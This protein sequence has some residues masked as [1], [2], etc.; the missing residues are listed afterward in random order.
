MMTRL[1]RGS[2]N[3]EWGE[4]TADSTEVRT[5]MSLG[6]PNFVGLRVDNVGV[7]YVAKMNGMDIIQARKSGVELDG[8]STTVRLTGEIDN[9]RIPVWWVSHVNNGEVSEVIVEPS[10]S[11]EDPLGV[12][13]VSLEIPKLRH[14]I[15]TDILD[16]LNTDEMREKE[17]FG[18]KFLRFRTSAEWGEATVD[19]TPL[20]MTAEIENPNR[21]PVVFSRLS[22]DIEM[23]GVEVGS[24]ET[25]KRVRLSPR[26]EQDVETSATIDNSTLSDWWVT[27]V[28]NDE[29]TEFK[30]RFKAVMEFAGR[31]V[32]IPLQSYSTTVET[33]IFGD[34]E[35]IT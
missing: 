8:T 27:H 31:K 18:K 21:F 3:N 16:S 9:T 1:V 7:G 22:Y 28:R 15:R 4:V 6:Y 23:N 29:T 12:A 2:L 5:R 20:E 33:D 24:G 17:L 14:R 11:V 35:R 13:D 34:L 25:K 30:L 19:S 26:G 10:I 32:E